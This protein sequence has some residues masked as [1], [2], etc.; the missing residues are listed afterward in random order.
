MSDGPSPQDFRYAVVMVG[1]EWRIIG[2]RRAMGHFA[3]REMALTAAANLA[4]Q[5]SEA[6]HRAEVLL[7]SESGELTP[8]R[9]AGV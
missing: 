5:A 2:A 1:P 7:Q 8:L 4:R 3:S 6:G 9:P